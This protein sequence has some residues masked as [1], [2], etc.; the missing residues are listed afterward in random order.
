MGPSQAIPDLR[1]RVADCGQ[2]IEEGAKDAWEEAQRTFF[3][4]AS[5]ARQS[6]RGQ[7]RGRPKGK[8]KAGATGARK[9]VRKAAHR[10]LKAIDRCLVDSIGA[11]LSHF[12]PGALEDS[13]TQPSSQ[14]KAVWD[15]PTL[16]LHMDEGSIGFASPWY[17]Q[18]HLVDI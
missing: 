13:S 15:L 18:Y 10:Q 5:R 6:G 12:L 2:D 14:G 8:A 1:L 4:P 7:G 17:L 9:P 11:G 16:V 3:D